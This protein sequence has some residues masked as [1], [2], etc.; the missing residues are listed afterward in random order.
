MAWHPVIR[1]INAAKAL[2]D[3][4]YI[5]EGPDEDTVDSAHEEL[6]DALQELD[7]REMA[8]HNS[9]NSGREYPSPR[10]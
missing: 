4:Y 5:H 6:R 7:D 3:L 10:S 8:I 2:N 1:V 9:I